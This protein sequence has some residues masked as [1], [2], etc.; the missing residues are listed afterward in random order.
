REENQKGFLIFFLFLFIGIKR[1]TGFFVFVFFF[2]L[3]VFLFFNF[4]FSKKPNLI[5]MKDVPSNKYKTSKVK[6]GLPVI[7]SSPMVEINKPI[8]PIISPLT[9]DCPDTLIIITKPNIASAKYSGGPKLNAND[10]IGFAN[11]NKKKVLIIP[12]SAE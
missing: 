10:A 2:F 11:I 4:A 12:P 5:V 1:T 6:L 8:N 7:E 9:T 3:E